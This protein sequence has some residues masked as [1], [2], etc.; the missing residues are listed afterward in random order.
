MSAHAVD[1]AA[2]RRRRTAQ[3]DAWVAGSIAA[4]GGAEEELGEGHGAA[5]DVAAEEVGVPRGE[6]FGVAGAAGEDAVAEAGCEAGDLGL[7]G[8]GAIYDGAGGDVAVG[9]CGVLSLRG[10]RRV[11]EAWLDQQDVGAVLVA[12]PSLRAAGV[13]L[14]GGGF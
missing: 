11:E 8:G 5:G 10:T 7:D 3:I 9:P 14:G 2:W 6:G 12:A 1:A 4:D 13:G